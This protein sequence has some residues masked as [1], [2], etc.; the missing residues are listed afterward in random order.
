MNTAA[1][2]SVGDVLVNNITDKIGRFFTRIHR[3]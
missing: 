1:A 3:S 2:L